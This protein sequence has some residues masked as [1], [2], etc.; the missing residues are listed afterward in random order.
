MNDDRL[1]QIGEQLDVSPQDIRKLKKQSWRQRW[2]PTLLAPIRVPFNYLLMGIVFLLAYGVGTHFET[3]RSSHRFYPY[4]ALFF[5]VCAYTQTKKS[6]SFL[7]KLIYFAIRLLI[8]L[9]LVENGSA[10]LGRVQEKYG[11]YQNP[12]GA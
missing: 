2:L 8:V 4:G 3:I 10:L 11:V 7:K 12:Q 6:E 9:Y 1:K 5:P